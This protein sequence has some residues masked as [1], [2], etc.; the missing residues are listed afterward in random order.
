M[1]KLISVIIPVYCVEKYLCECL[2]SVI[3][4]TY[5]NL[6]IILVD[7]GST[8]NSGNICDIYAAKDRRITVVHQKNQGAGVAKN[9]GLDLIKG[10]YFSLIDSDDYLDLGYYETMIS[11]MEKYHADVIQ[12]LFNNVFKDKTI[13]R[14]Y[15]FP[16]N[17]QRAMKAKNY[18]LEM[19]YDWKYAIFANKVFK[20]YL[21]RKDIRFPVD[22]KIDDEF[23]TYKLICNA[24]K[25]V[26]IND[27][28][29][30]YRMRKSSVMTSNSIVRSKNNELLIDRVFCF[31]ERYYY[32]KKFYNEIS[33]IYY[34]H[35][36]QYLKLLD[37]SQ[38]DTKSIN[39][40]NE[41]KKKF[42]V[43]DLS[44]K[45][46]V[47]IKIILRDYDEQ[48]ELNRKSFSCFE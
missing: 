9:T 1:E 13:K 44:I 43:V 5:R 37:L 31:N 2:D 32:I 10:E 42:P 39:Y 47:I 46:R 28:L 30:N 6:Q 20:S 26:N 16:A 18:L 33:S 36:S 14:N 48:K 27:A 8:D 41:I 24:N 4:Q 21:L 45:D 25:I 23:F 15:N 34:H 12:C 35:F 22:R 7:D 29:Y 11:N 19:L 3:N 40:I 38:A 17:K